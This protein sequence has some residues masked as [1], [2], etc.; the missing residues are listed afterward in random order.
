MCP[1]SLHL[2]RC[3]HH[4]PAAK[5]SAQ[6]VPL[7]SAAGLIPSL[8]DLILPIPGFLLIHLPRINAVFGGKVLAR[9]ALRKPPRGRHTDFAFVSQQKPKHKSVRDQKERHDKCR[10]KVGSAQLTGMDA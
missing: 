5:H 2:R 3:H 1:H 7:A 9:L 8:S 4:P 10:E 6:P